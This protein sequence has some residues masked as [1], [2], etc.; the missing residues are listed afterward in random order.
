MVTKHRERRQVP[1]NQF[2]ANIFAWKMLEAK[3]QY[4]IHIVVSGFLLPKLLNYLGVNV[5][6]RVNQL[7]GETCPHCSIQWFIPRIASDNG[8][9]SQLQIE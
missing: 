4:M 2:E 9:Y 6:V 7:T 1:F 5:C 8:L 3:K